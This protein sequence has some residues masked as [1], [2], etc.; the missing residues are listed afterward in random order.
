MDID[1]NLT[2]KVFIP[3]GALEESVGNQL[4]LAGAGPTLS[5]LIVNRLGSWPVGGYVTGRSSLL[6][7]QSE[8]R[9]YEMKG[10]YTTE[11]ED[12]ADQRKVIGNFE[13]GVGLQFEHCLCAPTCAPTCAT[14]ASGASLFVRVGYEAQLW[15][16]AGGPV[17]SSGA[18]GL[19]GVVLAIGLNR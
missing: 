3:V 9:I 18:I 17:D 19:D 7:V 15:L 2:G 4:Q 16:D 11:F 5:A 6:A 12:I 14:Y 8:Q 10:A 1:Q 13:L